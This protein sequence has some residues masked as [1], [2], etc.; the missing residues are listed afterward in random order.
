MY[1]I[2]RMTVKSAINALVDQ[3]LSLTSLQGKGPSPRR[4]IFT[5]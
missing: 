2:N 4:R 5:G 3:R 1:G